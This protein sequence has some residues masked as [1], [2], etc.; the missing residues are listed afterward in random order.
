MR[1]R[2]GRSSLLLPNTHITICKWK[3]N[4]PVHSLTRIR[5]L[6][7][8]V[9]CDWCIWRMWHMWQEI[10]YLWHSKT[11]IRVREHLLKKRMFSFGPCPNYPSPPPP[12][13][14]SGNLYIFFGRHKGIYKVYF[15]IRARPSPLPPHS[16]NARKKTFFF[17]GGVP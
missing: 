13:L 9:N 7:Y 8:Q 2:R 6:S 11:D 10:V 12:P 17:L 3:S 14:L 4:C 5:V 15:L 16:G 1:S